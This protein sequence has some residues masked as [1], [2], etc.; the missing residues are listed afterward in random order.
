MGRRPRSGR[1]VT[2]KA[3]SAQ[4]AGGSDRYQARPHNHSPGYSQLAEF[5]IAALSEKEKDHLNRVWHRLDPWPD[6]VEGLSRLKTRYIITTLSNGNVALLVNMAKRA[7]LPWDLI[8]SAELVRHYKP[9]PET[10]R[11]APE[12]LGLPPERIMMAAAHEQDLRAARFAGLR[13][14]F[15]H[16]PLEWGPQRAAG[17]RKPD[18]SEYDVVAG[19]ILDLAGKLGT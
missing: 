14:A 5:G 3:P 6:S 9:D 1:R 7:G 8:L 13:T 4:L 11:M 10:Y 15:V 16:R 19:D 2:S 12:L 17:I 18:E